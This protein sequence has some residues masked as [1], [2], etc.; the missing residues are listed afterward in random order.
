M[1]TKNRFL[2][3]AVTF[4]VILA[5]GCSAM[6][7]E[8]HQTTG[9]EVYSEGRLSSR[10]KRPIAVVQGAVVDAYKGFGIKITKASGDRLSGVVQG[11]LASGDAA[12]TKLSSI[13]E[14]KTS[15]SIKVGSDGNRYI[16][17]RLLVAIKNN[18]HVTD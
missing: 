12:D 8:R 11:E 16:S 15:I 3:L 9:S 17:H 5:S 1:K 4:F 13:S 10:I 2:V 7:Y 6:E 18:L 14:E